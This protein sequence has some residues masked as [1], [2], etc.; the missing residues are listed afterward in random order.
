MVVHMRDGGGTEGSI[1]RQVIQ[2][3]RVGLASFGM[4]LHLSN[5]EVLSLGPE[6]FSES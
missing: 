4:W 6:N 3:T 5:T 1:M 2:E